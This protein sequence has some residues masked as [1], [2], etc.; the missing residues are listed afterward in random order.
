[1]IYC[2]DTYL[3]TPIRPLEQ[4][5]KGFPC[6]VDKYVFLGGILRDLCWNPAE[7]QPRGPVPDLSLKKHCENSY[8]E[9]QI[10]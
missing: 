10:R 9:Q 1:M 5:L 2:W 3:N 6:F 7:T 4:T 8:E